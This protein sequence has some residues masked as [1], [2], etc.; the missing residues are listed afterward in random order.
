MLEK[1]SSAGCCVRLGDIDKLSLEL[2]TS[3][4][5]FTETINREN[6]YKFATLC[7]D[8]VLENFFYKTALEQPPIDLR[9]SNI[10]VTP[11]KFLDRRQSSTF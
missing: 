10:P 8:E 9:T 5:E 6:A 4:A 3:E 11:S 1:W 7:N 2:T